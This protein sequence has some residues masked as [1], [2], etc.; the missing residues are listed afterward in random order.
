MT[1]KEDVNIYPNFQVIPSR[2]QSFLFT[3]FF[4]SISL[5]S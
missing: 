3:R 4:T 2:N 5:L 1:K